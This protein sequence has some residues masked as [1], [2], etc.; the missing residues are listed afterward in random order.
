M[1]AM[2]TLITLRTPLHNMENP[3]L[4][5][6]KRKRK[7][8]NTTEDSAVSAKSFTDELSVMP[9]V[10][11]TAKSE[12]S[13]KS[14]SAPNDNPSTIFTAEL[15]LDQKSKKRR[16]GHENPL[17]SQQGS[18]APDTAENLVEE[19]AKEATPGE[20]EVSRKDE[21]ESGHDEEANGHE[22]IADT[23]MPSTSALSLPSTGTDPK[24]FSDL[25]LSSKTM[26]A[27]EA[28]EFDE[29]TEIQQRGI[30]PLL[31]GRDVLGAAKTGSGKTLAF[32]L[33]AVEMLSALRFKPRNGT[34]VIVVSP[35]RELALQIFGVARELMQAHSQ[36]T[37]PS[38]L[39]WIEADEA[40]LRNRYW[41][42]EQVRISENLSGLESR[43]LTLLFSGEPRLRSLSK[44]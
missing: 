42:C 44:A 18:A 35:T 38:I 26:Q 40:S 27:I 25:N 22:V 37:S 5:T 32:L 31:A 19:M 36:S 30:P 3:E 21:G 6:K 20:T 4:K 8:A 1:T 29:M 17:Q 7:H 11:R 28:M 39:F 43:R 2:S 12:P 14:N 16:L 9:S 34:G 13:K 24:R 33:P 41:G 10:N 15:G 23:D